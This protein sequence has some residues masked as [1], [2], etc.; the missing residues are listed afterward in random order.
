MSASGVCRGFASLKLRVVID[1]DELRW[2][3]VRNRDAT[4][5]GVFVYAVATTGVYCRPGCASRQPLRRN[6]EFFSGPADA[7]AAG[8]RACR[9]CRPDE[10][11][12]HDPAV[13]AVVELCQTLEHSSRDVDV[14]A[15][16]AEHGYSVRH[17]RRRFVELV[18]VTISGYARVARAERVRALLR[19]KV[20]V[21]QA[22]IDAGYGSSRAFYETGAA[23]LGMTP[24]AYRDG[25]RGV[26]ITFTS[27]VTPLGTVVAAATE[28]GVCAV[29]IGANEVELVHEITAEFPNSSFERDDDA[30]VGTALVLAG[31]VRGEYDATVLPIDV[32]GTAFQMRVWDVLRKVPLGDTLTYSQVAE[33]IGSPRAVRAV[34]SA[35]AANPAA[36]VVPC[37][38]IVRR[39][40]SLGGYRWGLDVKD[41]LLD[42]ER[43]VDEHARQ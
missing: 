41:A 22:A 40:G 42:A 1:L 35:C 18:G 2:N 34:G 21:T 6:V 20:P 38:R 16:A 27:L 25:G 7:V 13:D 11:T 43:P 23:Q 19:A 4:A 29:R 9:R 30:L 33:R 8:Y 37:H 28:R 31:A 5:A 3:V 15:F 36:L 14:V 24:R 26:R 12:V 39:D 32:Q 17:L 10:S